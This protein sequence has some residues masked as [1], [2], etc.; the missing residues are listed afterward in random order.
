[1][2]FAATK[3]TFRLSL[4]VPLDLGA[5]LAYAAMDSGEARD[6]VGWAHPDV[7]AAA[8]AVDLGP[9][10]PGLDVAD[11][12]AVIVSL[13]EGALHRLTPLGASGCA[14]SDRRLA[15]RVGPKV[16]AARDVV[17]DLRP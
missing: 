10:G 2:I 4:Q 6:E 11:T 16:L 9:A 7:P 8:I 17:M 5:E 3:A 14:S 12:R 15:R 13:L 1:M